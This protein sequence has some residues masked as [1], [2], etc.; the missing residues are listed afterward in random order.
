[1]EKKKTEKSVEEMK[2]ERRKK[3]LNE[4]VKSYEWYCD[5]CQ[6]RKNYTYRGTSMHLKTKKHNR[7]LNKNVPTGKL[8]EL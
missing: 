3:Y 1:M 8:I 2:R 4:K 7:N 5:V 6:N